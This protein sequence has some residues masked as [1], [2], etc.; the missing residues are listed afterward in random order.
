MAYIAWE[1]ER[2]FRKLNDFFQVILVT[3]ARQVSKTTIPCEMVRQA[4]IT[5]KTMW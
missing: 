1:L 5:M 3:G 4:A 2:K